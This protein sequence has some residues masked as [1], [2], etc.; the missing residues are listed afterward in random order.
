[1]TPGIIIKDFAFVGEDFMVKVKELKV[2]RDN[3]I[4][5]HSE[6]YSNEFKVHGAANNRRWTGEPC[7]ASQ[8]AL[9]LMI[10]KVRE[11]V[12]A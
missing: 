2:L 5:S 9:R 11:K 8:R 3:I 6:S 12:V 10:R 7:K 1:M 4:K